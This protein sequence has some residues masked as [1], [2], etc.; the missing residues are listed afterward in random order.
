[1]TTSFIPAGVGG[2]VMVHGVDPDADAT[3]PDGFRT[4]S[5]R[6]MRATTVTEGGKVLNIIE[7]QLYGIEPWSEAEPVPPQSTVY[8]LPDTEDAQARLQSYANAHALMHPTHPCPRWTAYRHV[9]ADM[10]VQLPNIWN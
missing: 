10:R 6:L 3:G 4:R 5:Y 9:I 2:W 7:P 1:M 8:V